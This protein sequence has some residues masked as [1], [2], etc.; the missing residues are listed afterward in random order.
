[1]KQAIGLAVIAALVIGCSATAVDSPEAPTLEA[2]ATPTITPEPTPEP[3]EAPT[4]EP[5]PTIDPEIAY[6]TELVISTDGAD[7]DDVIDVMT[8]LVDGDY[9]LID[10]S[11]DAQMI[12]VESLN[13][14]GYGDPAKI[15]FRGKG[16]QRTKAQMVNY[17]DYEIRI[18]GSRC[19]GNVIFDLI[20][21]GGD[22]WDGENL[23]NEIVWNNK[24]FS[25]TTYA[26][27]VGG[28]EYFVDG[29]GTDCR[30]WTITLI[31][32]E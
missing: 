22:Y 17:G 26:Y 6:L 16:G 10:L 15:V 19:D 24:P 21:K 7:C 2:T 25:L 23:S 32:Q 18:K 30:S 9:H 29:G 12:G 20:P 3:T 27:D 31:P 1:M 11:D 8:E 4:P 14:C 5:T 13:R 28:E